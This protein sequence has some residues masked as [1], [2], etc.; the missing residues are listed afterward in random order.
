[1]LGK[2]AG[3]AAL[4]S[5]AMGVLMS[6]EE[7]W[8]DDTTDWVEVEYSERLP[9]QKVKCY[10]CPFDCLLYKGETCR[11]RTRKNVG[12]RLLNP[13]WNN[14]CIIRMDPVEKMPLNHF[15]PG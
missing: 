7:A 5:P 15:L 11:C 14:P 3:T 9:G 8:A 1:M 6:L 4:A 2:V 10:V 13:G 12:G